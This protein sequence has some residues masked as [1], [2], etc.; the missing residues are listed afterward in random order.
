M[1]ST[2]RNSDTASATREAILEAAEVIVREEGYAAVSSRKVA[3]RAGLKSQLVHYYFRTMD[4]LFLAL[5]HRVEAEHFRRLSEAVASKHPLRA[6]W[7]FS[8]DVDGPRLTHEFMAL[9][10][11]RGVIR[12]EM[13]RSAKRTRSIQCALLQRVLEER[14]VGKTQIAPLVLSVLFTGAAR[15]MVSEQPLGISVGHAET[16][17]FIEG[18]LNLLEPL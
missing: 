14:Y 3:V 11:Q 2:Q 10:A 4:D 7:A 5:F 9:A 16:V 1:A 12:R 15:V 18:Y 8:I 13:A 6:L 17:A